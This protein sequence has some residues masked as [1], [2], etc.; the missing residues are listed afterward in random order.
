MVNNVSF[1]GKVP[2]NNLDKKVV[3]TIAKEVGYT[4]PYSLVEKTSP[5]FLEEASTISKEA[6]EAI[7]ITRSPINIEAPK[8]ISDEALNSYLASIGK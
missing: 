3:E 8:V 2:V 6:A 1:T 5:K 7:K 4:S